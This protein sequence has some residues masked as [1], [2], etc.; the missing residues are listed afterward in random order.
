[1]STK[2]DLLYAALKARVGRDGTIPDLWR[3]YLLSL[4]YSG[5]FPDMAAKHAAALGVSVQA[6]YETDG[7]IFAAAPTGVFVVDSTA[8]N[9][10]GTDFTVNRPAGVQNGDFLVFFIYF[11]NH[12]RTIAASPAG[13]TQYLYDTVAL[14]DTLY[15]YTK[16]AGASEPATYT[17]S[18]EGVSDRG[19]VVCVALRGATTINSASVV[20]RSS[21]TGVSTSNSFTSTSPGYQLF[22]GCIDSGTAPAV[23]TPPA[24]FTELEYNPAAF[25]SMWVGGKAGVEPATLLS[26]SIEWNNGSANNRTNISLIVGDAA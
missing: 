6:Y 11:S 8:V 9:S 10:I 2:P 17:F 21:G 22:C 15:I 12:V 5:T 3:A 13:T 16:V 20:A 19:A 18:N 23:T 7:S 26:E 1:M 4:G 14:L 25:N 24:G